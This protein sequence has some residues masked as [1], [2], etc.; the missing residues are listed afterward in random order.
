MRIHFS[1]QFA[2]AAKKVFERLGARSLT[3]RIEVIKVRKIQKEQLKRAAGTLVD[4]VN[5][6]YDKQES[7]RGSQALGLLRGSQEI[8]AHMLD[9]V[10]EL[11]GPGTE[12]AGLL[13]EYYKE[14]YR[15]SLQTGY[16]AVRLKGFARL[17][18]E[19][20]ENEIKD[21]KIEMLFLPYKAAMWDSM[22][23]V[24]RAASEDPCCLAYVVPVPYCERGPGGGFGRFVCEAGGFPGYVPVTGWDIYDMESRRPDVIIIHNPYDGFNLITSV[25][26][27]FYA[28]KLSGYTNMLVYIPYFVTAGDSPEHFAKTSGV[29]YGDRV[30][31][32]S[33]KVRRTYM[34]SFGAWLKEAEGVKDIVSGHPLWDKITGLE[35]KFVALGSPKFDKVISSKDDEFGLPGEWKSLI[36]QNGL[37]KPMVLYNTSFTNLE[38]EAEIKLD[39]LKR[40]LGEFKNQDKAVLW[41]RPHPLSDTT[42]VSLRPGLAEEYRRLVDEYRREGWGI[43]DDTPDLYR[44]LRLTSCMYGEASSLA[45]MY[46]CMGKPVFAAKLQGAGG[47]DKLV[48]A[49]MLDAGEHYWFSA[50]EFNALFKINKTSFELECAGGF[51]GEEPDGYRMY[52]SLIS[53]G[54]KLYFAP[55][56]AGGIGVYDV[57]TGS[58]ERIEVPAPVQTDGLAR[59]YEEKTKFARIIHAEG[60]LYFL[61]A[62]Y[63]GIL[64]YDTLKKTLEIRNDW[65]KPLNEMIFDPKLSYFTGGVVDW[66]KRAVV[67]VC[68]AA[69]AVAEISLD[70]GVSSVKSLGN[71][72]TPYVDIIM[73]DGFYWLLVW[74]AAALARVDPETY[75]RKEFTAD[76]P[77]FKSKDKK[78][79]Q[80]I[81]RFGNLLYLT[82]Y[83]AERP[84]V[85]DMETGVF[86]YAEPADANSG[87]NFFMYSEISEKVVANS[88]DRYYLTE[89]DPVTNEKR[90]LKMDMDSVKNRDELK[91]LLVK[92]RD[93]FLDRSE[94]AETAE[95]CVIS[96]RNCYMT[97]NDMAELISLNEIPESLKKLLDRQAGLCGKEISNFGGT[98]GKAIYEHC[99]NAVLT[100]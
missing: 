13:E 31:L 52:Y 5:E 59:G 86:S 6:I 75:E 93:C 28:E 30:I 78:W 66:R 44:S 46:Q 22:E 54:G 40:A 63:P 17:I 2:K 50:L 74:G 19:S 21:D 24:W 68:A 43:Y 41:W 89:F 18:E 64:I 38:I 37:K 69:D 61:P 99:R 33:E 71:N 81:T 4:A 96:E 8:T 1:A 23:S 51:P 95:R 91:A 47:E 57:E 60:F 48:A 7:G 9:F 29:L 32:Q 15:A 73:A 36:Y 90:G 87:G 56:S 14:L 53:R 85:F 100:L 10:E 27:K 49:N 98:A 65:L 26:P 35:R 76:L 39:K 82:P 83:E 42:L 11:E 20:A 3:E 92:A 55:R 88:K 12:T 62:S 79:F 84:V 70:G 67:A 77:E 34:R 72:N 97:V 58:F 25:H 16:N 80:K 45:P 94:G